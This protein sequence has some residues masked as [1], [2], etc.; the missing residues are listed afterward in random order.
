MR[1]ERVETL[2]MQEIAKIIQ[3]RLSNHKIGF[4]SITGVSITKDLSKAR[5]YYSQ[6]GSDD[7]KATTF[8]ALKKRLDLLKVN[9][10]APFD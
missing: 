3:S 2:L 4:I 9:L 6:I 10:D 1:I 7:E 5:V 8:E